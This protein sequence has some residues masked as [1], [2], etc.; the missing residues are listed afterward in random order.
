MTISA[1]LRHDY[2]IAVS[3][4]IMPETAIDPR[5]RLLHCRKLR[6]VTSFLSV[7]EA[8]AH[9]FAR[10]I[11]DFSDI[12]RKMQEVTNLPLLH[13]PEGPSEVVLLRIRRRKGESI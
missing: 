1:S 7:S 3:F 2:S 12:S 5:A 10:Y 6:V 9:Y 8:V 13:N 11:A 4:A